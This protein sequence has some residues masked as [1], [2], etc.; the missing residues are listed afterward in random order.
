MQVC[1]SISLSSTPIGAIEGMF[2]Y[3]SPA[4]PSSLLGASEYHLLE[5]YESYCA[6]VVAGSRQIPA[7]NS[8]RSKER[9]IRTSFMVTSVKVDVEM[10]YPISHRM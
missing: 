3:G 1:R 5:K 8:A 7:M 2:G 10:S 6:R 9:A 4:V